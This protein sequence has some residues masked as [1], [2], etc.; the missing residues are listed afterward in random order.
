M[1]PVRETPMNSAGL[2]ILL[3]L[4]LAFQPAL[5]KQNSQ[6]LSEQALFCPELGKVKLQHLHTVR[7]WTM[8]IKDFQQQ[9]CLNILH[10]PSRHLHLPILESRF[11]LLKHL[12][13]HFIHP[14]SSLVKQTLC[15]SLLYK[16]SWEP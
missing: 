16:A 3:S 15:S 2:G 4:L 6:F 14:T 9:T 8:S 11:K 12:G 5:L 1:D 7:G 13:L 10:F